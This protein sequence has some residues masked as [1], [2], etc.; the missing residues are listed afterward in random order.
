MWKGLP[1]LYLLSILIVCAL[2]AAGQERLPVAGI[3]TFYGRGTHADVLIGRV[4]ET[5]TLN[6]KGRPSE[7]K[8]V[9]LYV[10]QFGDDDISRG[11]SEKYRFPI[12]GQVGKTLTL[13]TGKLAVDGVLLVAEHGEY[14][15]STTGQMVFPKRR[16]FGEV[17][18]VFD[19][20]GR[21]VPLFS[22]KHLADN[23]KDAK[24]IYDTAKKMGV[25]LMAGS[26]VPSA[27]RFPEIDVE[28][29]VELKEIVGVGYGPLDAYGFHALEMV[30]AL[31][32]RR[33][34]GE[35]GVARV[36][37]LSGSQV[38]KG[39]HFDRA[40]LDAALG[41][42]KDKPLPKGKGI[43]DLV[44]E[45]VLIAV[46]YRDGLRASILMLSEPVQE[47]AS[48]WRYKDRSEPQAALFWLQPVRPFHH[49]AYLLKGV[50]RFMKTKQATW[51]VE[52]TLLTTGVLDAV[53]I[54]KTNGGEWL[55]TPYLAIRYTSD[56]NWSQPPP[57]PLAEE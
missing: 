11:L 5:D 10:D 35:T 31:A 42:L 4:L 6:G 2:E 54:S 57:P 33:K 24:W 17:F 1:I 26:S 14:P 45:P 53:H 7:L 50:E 19:R 37:C 12:F 44:E 27:W 43:E 41:K 15:I 34:S 29:G 36:R 18:K 8:L 23:W 49:F 56:W 25:P 55:E 13:D 46:E 30:Q 48:A 9:S 52:R 20:S 40:L 32:E 3:T 38:W 28:K 22:D 16:L 47:F 51:P 39:G 21:V